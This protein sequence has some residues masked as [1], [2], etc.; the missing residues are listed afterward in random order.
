M[1]DSIPHWLSRRPVASALVGVLALGYPVSDAGRETA[2]RAAAP[3]ASS[4]ASRASS[5]AIPSRSTAGTFASK[6]STRRRPRRRAAAA[7]SARGAAARLPPTALAKLVAK[8]RV[9]CESRGTDKYDRMLGICFVDGRDINA[10]MV[11]EG[12]AWAFVKYS[13][14]YVQR[15]G[16]G[17]RR[18]RRHLA[19]R[20]RAG[21]GLSRE[22]LGRCRAG[23]R[24][25]A[26]PSRA[27]SPRTG[28]SITCRGAP[29]TARSR[30]RRR[31]ASAGSAARPRPW[32]PAGG[33][34]RVQ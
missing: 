3:A 19:G 1:S 8:R 26:A 29:G 9:S 24:R 30:S 23:R 16:R 32:R 33:R 25:R 10:E 18:A 31:R 12:F 15:G 20:G 7:S 34:R 11:R 4:P 14:S 5:T 17:A 22:A 21:V 6:A 28:T 2:A 13:Q 27:T